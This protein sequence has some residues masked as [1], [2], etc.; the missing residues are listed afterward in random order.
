MRAVKPTPTAK[1]R[2]RGGA[3]ADILRAHMSRLSRCS[4]LALCAA[5]LLTTTACLS[6]RGGT[7][8]KHSA[9]GV[10]GKPGAPTRPTSLTPAG[11]CEE[12]ALT[13]APDTV[14]GKV[15]GADIKLSELG[16][17]L[18]AA[19]RQALRAYCKA[20]SESRKQAFDNHVHK[21]LLDEAAK[22]E[23]KSIQDFLKAR[24]DAE[25][26]PPDDAA[27]QAFYD[28]N[29]SEQTPPLELVR[30][31]VIQ[32]MT[33]DQTDAALERIIAGIEA[34]NGVERLLDD[35]QM[36]PV[37]LDNKP[38]TATVGPDDAVVKVVEFSDFECPFCERAANTFRQLKDKYAGQKVQFVFRNFPLPMH[39]NA[40]PAAEHAQCAQ[41]QGKFWPMHDAIFA[42]FRELSKDKLKEMATQAGLDMDALE[43]CLSKGEAAQQVAA[44]LNLGREAGV[45]GTP[46]FY[47]NGQPHTG[48]PSFEGL[49]KAIDAELAKAAR[50]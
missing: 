38:Y 12:A 45:E 5:F 25:V 9:A 48:N 18:P 19:E 2:W 24:V 34:E 17:E 22:K 49:S 43:G 44:D 33:G 36:A 1:G 28:A 20:I 29:K 7:P 13:L 37:N 26:T 50:G 11:S 3:G 4:S 30:D 47:I 21:T 27:I 35:V 15:R 6:E 14:V 40:Q 8:V 31:Q 23:G 39:A 10:P 42:G 46:S 41:E 16:E 32:S